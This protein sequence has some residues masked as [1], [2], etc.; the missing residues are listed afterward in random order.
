MPV[1]RASLVLLLAVALT[2]AVPA[3]ASAEGGTTHTPTIASC[4]GA[5]CQ[6]A[7]DP[8]ASGQTATTRLG[9]PQRENG[10]EAGYAL[11]G[12]LLLLLVSIPVAVTWQ[13]TV[14][15]KAVASDEEADITATRPRRI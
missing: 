15:E 12:L 10:G 3:V 1:G 2:L 7:L 8:A 9:T 6:P 4:T 13:R 11:Y 5:G 14:R